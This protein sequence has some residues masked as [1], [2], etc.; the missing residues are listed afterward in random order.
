LEQF[1][2]E[3]PGSI[4]SAT[5]GIGNS[6]L[7]RAEEERID[8]VEIPIVPLKEVTEQLSVVS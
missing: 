7:G 3:A 8:L 2:I 4:G 5:G 1:G 6:N